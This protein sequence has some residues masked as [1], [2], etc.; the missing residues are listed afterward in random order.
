MQA[1][2]FVGRVLADGHLSLPESAAKEVGKVFEVI[3]IPM[4]ETEIYSY[5]EGLA[6]EKGFSKLTEDDVANIIHDS[7]LPPWREPY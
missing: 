1:E 3:L 7:R 2:R 5:A 4:Q 6:T